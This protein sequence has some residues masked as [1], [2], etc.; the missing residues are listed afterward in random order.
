MPRALEL[1]IQIGT[2]APGP[3]N[4]ILDVP[5]VG[6]GHATLIRDETPPPHGRGIARTGVTVVDF[7]GDHWAN[8]LPL[9]GA[10]LN[11]AGECTGLLTAHEWGLLETPIFLTSTMQ[12]GRVY[13]AA[14]ELLLEEQPGIIDDVVIPVV[15]ECDD[16]FLSFSGRMQVSKDDVAEALAAARASASTP[17]AAAEGGVGAGAG[18][19]CFGWKGGVGTSSRRVGNY[20][21]GV[22]LLTNFGQADRLTVAGVQVGRS[23]VPPSPTAPPGGSCIGIVATNAPIDHHG[24]ERLARRIGL[25]LGRSG[26]T[27]HH[28]SGEI[29]LGVATGLRSPRGLRPSGSGLGGVE[30]DPFFEAVIDASEE[31]VLN[32]LFSATTTVGTSGHVSHALPLDDLLALLARK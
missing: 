2:L 6:V 1:G 11:G 10:V 22:L 32:S 17:E 26:S 8:P 27:A 20:L 12:L 4:S 25:G 16:S 15:A 3:T 14:C 28:S 31:A 19:S 9:G 30:L 13:D 5:G 24:C 23:L 29:F 21:V 18:M 7:G